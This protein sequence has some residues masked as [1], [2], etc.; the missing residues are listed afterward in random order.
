M[1]SSF[2]LALIR[3]ISS[4]FCALLAIATVHGCT[5]GVYPLSLGKPFA[6]VDEEDRL[7]TATHE[8][9][10]A[11]LGRHFF[12]P[13]AV[14]WVSIRM[15]KNRGK[16][17][18][19]TRLDPINLYT[20][21]QMRQRIM[22]G[23]GGIIA[24]ELI[25]SVRPAIGL[26]DINQATADATLLVTSY[27]ENSV[28]LRSFKK[29]QLDFTDDTRRRIA[30]DVD[31]VIQSCTAEVRALLRQH[32]EEVIALRQKLLERN[33][34]RSGEVEEILRAAAARKT[35]VGDGSESPILKSPCR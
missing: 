3:V 12:G 28:G 22:I 33:M 4:A 23:L 5:H 21:T 31:K 26:E 6:F 32:L 29:E 15:P 13:E 18:F 30:A 25:H 14:L 17:E 35:K 19:H 10:H 11:F 9:A 16:V 7:F 2:R 1:T 24:Q 27:G 20:V 34:L 8:A